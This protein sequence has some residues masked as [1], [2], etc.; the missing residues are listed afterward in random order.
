MGDSSEEESCI[1]I[2]GEAGIKHGYPKGMQV[3]QLQQMKIFQ[4]WIHFLLKIPYI[5]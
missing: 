3:K 1:I 5:P 2:P 4:S